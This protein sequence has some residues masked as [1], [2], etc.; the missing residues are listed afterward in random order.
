MQSCIVHSRAVVKCV[1]HPRTG[2]TYPVTAQSDTALA[3]FV[4]RYSHLRN[5]EKPCSF[6]LD[7]DLAFR[8][9]CAFDFVTSHLVT[10]R[11]E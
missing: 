4:V 2:Q 9:G 1:N 8:F 5:Q 7:L 10:Q 6:L 11:L 3:R